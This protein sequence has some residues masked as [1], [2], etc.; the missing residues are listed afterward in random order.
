MEIEFR[1]FEPFALR[2]QRS[3][4]KRVVWDLVRKKW[5]RLTSEEWVRQQWIHFLIGEGASVGKMAVEYQLK[6]LGNKNLRF[7]L[8]LFHDANQCIL[9]AEFKRME[10]EIKEETLMQL[11]SYAK[12]L[13]PLY[14]LLSNYNQNYVWSSSH[15]SWQYFENEG[16]DLIN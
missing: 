14:Y 16:I 5:V 4:A 9:L 6:P 10:V 7:D 11:L 2:V 15:Q 8:A 12:L 13:K 3:G 1:T